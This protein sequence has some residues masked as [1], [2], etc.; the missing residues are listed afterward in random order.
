MSHRKYLLDENINP[1][2]KKALLRQIPDMVVRCVGDSGA[3]PLQTGD[4]DILAWCEKFYF[5]NKQ[6][7]INACSS[8]RSYCFGSPY[9][10]DFHSESQHNN[11]GNN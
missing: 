9:S 2:L 1:R 3:P 7:G 4:P 10:G 5:G 6:P 11:A 8:Q